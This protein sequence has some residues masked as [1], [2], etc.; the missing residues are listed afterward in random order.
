[1]HRCP[2]CGIEHNRHFDIVIGN[3][4]LRY[5]FCSDECMG[6]AYDRD[7]KSKTPNRAWQKRK[8]ERLRLVME[9][10]SRDRWLTPEEA[11]KKTWEIATQISLCAQATIRS[12]YPDCNGYWPF[13]MYQGKSIATIDRPLNREIL[14]IIAAHQHQPEVVLTKVLSATQKRYE[15]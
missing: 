3:S 7:R 13:G 14:Q 11:N 6:K 9:R 10:L 12:A 15:L 2:F 1:M 5:A 8:G 4:P